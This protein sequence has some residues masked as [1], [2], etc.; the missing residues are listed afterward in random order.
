MAGK[1]AGKRVGGVTIRVAPD[2]SKFREELRAQLKG[3]QDDFKV[4]VDLN[5]S[6]AKASFQA[7]KQSIEAQ[8]IEAKLDLDS[9]GIQSATRA[10]GGMRRP[11]APIANLFTG[12]ANQ[13]DKAGRSA[14]NMA[15][16]IVRTRRA[17]AASVSQTAV[18]VAQM[19]RVA[20]TTDNARKAWVGLTRAIQ[21]SGTAIAKIPRLALLARDLALS[22][23]NGTKLAAVRF[24][25]MVKSLGDGATYANLFYWNMERLSEF[26]VKVANGFDRIRNV[27]LAD[28]RRGVVNLGRSA[29]KAVRSVGNLGRTVGRVFGKGADR[30]ILGFG[31]G[32]RRAFSGVAGLFS[33]A[34]RGMMKFS[35][36][37]LI[38][39]AVVAVLAPALGL[40]S[41]LLAGLPSLAFVAGGA[42][43]A[44]ALGFD[45]IKQAAQQ[46]IPLVDDLKASLSDTFARELTPVFKE[47]SKV[48]PTL[49]DG[50]NSVAEGL[51]PLVQGFT[52]V[53]TS[54]KGL[55]QL[56]TI[57][58][59]TGEFLAS[60]KPMV[61]DFMDAF[62]TLAEAGSKS[63]GFLG[64]ML[65]EF[66][67]N[68][69]AMVQR[70][71]SN[72]TFANAMEG[73]ADA[74]GG[75][76]DMF[77]RLMEVGLEVMG[78]L[79]GPIATFFK[80]FTDALVALMPVL[81]DLSELLLNVLGESLSSLA[82]VVD[83]LAPAFSKLAGIVGDLFVG[84]I[85][86]LQPILEPLATFIGDVLVR[87][88][89]AI[90]PFIPVIVDFF[91]QLGEIVGTAL[92]GALEALKPLLP[93][94]LK[95]FT[96][97]LEAIKPLLPKLLELA[98]TVLTALVD[99][100]PKILPPLMELIKAVLPVL[101]ELVEILVPVIGDLADIFGT[102]FKEV[103]KVVG[104]IA[105]ELQPVFQALADF[106]EEVWPHIKE[107][108]EGALQS[109]R[110]IIK[111]VTG[112]IGG[113][114]EKVW[115][116]IKDIIKGAW[117]MIK[118]AVKAGI[119]TVVAL[120]YELP[121]KIL[122]AIGDLGKLLWDAGWDL[123]RGFWGGIRSAESWLRNKISS[124]F[125]SL[126]PGWAKGFL[127]IA[128]P[129]KVFAAIGK[130][131]PPGFAKGIT[132]NAKPAFD[133]ARKLSEGVTRSFGPIG[134]SHSL[135]EDLAKD[136][137][138]GITDG[139]P[140]ALR[141]IDRMSSIS[142]AVSAEIDGTVSAEGFGSIGDRVAEALESWEVRLDKNGIAKLVNTSNRMMERRK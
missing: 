42:I 32:I 19:V 76:L 120:F 111:V 35:R 129:S 61:T 28:V 57:L 79:G 38:V 108:I 70:V 34:A 31:K 68:F 56:K 86:A 98:E 43:A 117:K 53:V 12:M 122:G 13:M 71:T 118:G 21:A 92:V 97:M 137:A 58:D 103:T 136:W 83:A 139:T 11:L 140:S 10:I 100:L 125:G 51:T 26:T 6:Q 123:I 69:N 112:I 23:K 77:T 84:A 8:K 48:F 107:V 126:V 85:E 101:L 131:I 5:T 113:D 17:V 27:K 121:G 130:W 20:I 115:D 22:A 14:E 16:S 138:K 7:L 4:T 132:D 95:F 106:I 37:G 59:N 64:T 29:G 134:G 81:S 50:L 55:A 73:M 39:G 30:G 36:T 3:I 135:G 75:F 49:K 78:D 87:A 25:R 52:D 63:F 89:E 90:E 44:I 74:V 80:G 1:P 82:P 88:F 2:T 141:A 62:L 18:W 15:K 91:T 133:A 54:T 65:N 47:L 67:S 94:F 24:G 99:L 105:E 72:D 119:R 60:L 46:M 116:G 96:D 66:G 40:I 142:S 124:F 93:V 127:G 33:K 128:S 45:G 110:G 102:V 41:G 109:I 9:S 114:W 104:V